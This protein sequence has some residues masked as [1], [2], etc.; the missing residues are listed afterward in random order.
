MV[1]SP[2]SNVAE[3]DEQES[4]ESDAREDVD[5]EPA[6][7]ADA[8]GNQKRTPTVTTSSGSQT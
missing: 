7:D 4:Q 3:A 5:N 6:E 2:A 8:E 1:S